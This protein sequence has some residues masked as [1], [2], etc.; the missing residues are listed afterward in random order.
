MMICPEC[1]KQELEDGEK[2]CP[3]CENKSDR[4]IVKAVTIGGIILAGLVAFFF[5]GSD[6]A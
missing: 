5:K 1:K 4:N 2:V 6:S 3:H